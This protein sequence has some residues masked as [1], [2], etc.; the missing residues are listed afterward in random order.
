MDTLVQVHAEVVAIAV[1][2]AFASGYV[3]GKTV[4]YLKRADHG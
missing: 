4:G 3:I 1:I 2:V